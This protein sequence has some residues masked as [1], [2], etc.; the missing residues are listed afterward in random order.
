MY[1]NTPKVGN[2]I[3]FI[4]KHRLLLIIFSFISVFIVFNFINPKLFSSDE[5]IWLQDSKELERTLDKNL[6]SQHVS[7][8]SL[9]VDS[10]DIES[11][12]ILKQLNKKT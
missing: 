7:K 11:I 12:E 2:Y 5:R 6:E 1:Y 10:F 9:H 8:I 4:I 3:S